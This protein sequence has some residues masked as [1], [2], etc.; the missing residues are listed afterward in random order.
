MQAAPNR[1]SSARISPDRPVV[2][3]ITIV[4]VAT[5]MLASYAFSFASIAD[6]ARWTGVPAWAHWLAPVFIDGAIITYT[7]SLAVMRWRGEPVGRTLLFLSSFTAIS[8]LV[9][10][11][12]AAAAQSW[13]FGR[14]ET[15][16]G[17]LIGIAAPL[18]ALFAAEESTRLVFTRPD[19]GAGPESLSQ[20]D[21]R[22][23]DAA[24]GLPGHVPEVEPDHGTLDLNTELADETELPEEG[25]LNVHDE[26]YAGLTAATWA[27]PGPVL[28][29]V[30]GRDDEVVA[31][32]DGTPEVIIAP[33]KPTRWGLDERGRLFPAQDEVRA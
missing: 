14:L 10:F 6:A 33:D 21:E 2:A 17:C 32:P 22:T 16:F 3:G 18:A 26:D 29:E 5:I 4:L 1:R 30:S 7:L 8:V 27:A 11:S 19:D 24:V 9:N 25:E 23:E 20:S 12:H 28:P 15:W 13:D 31:A